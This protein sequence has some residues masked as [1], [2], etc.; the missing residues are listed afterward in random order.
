MK[1]RS[2]APFVLV[3]ACENLH[4]ITVNTEVCFCPFEEIFD[5][6]A[7]KALVCSGHFLWNQKNLALALCCFSYRVEYWALSESECLASFI[8]GQF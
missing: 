2:R 5:T 7:V 1:T 8:Q 3:A 4:G 6:L